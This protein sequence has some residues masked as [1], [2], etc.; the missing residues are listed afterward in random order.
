MS[1]TNTLGHQ[2][3][4]RSSDE[5]ARRVAEHGLGRRVRQGDQAF[6]IHGEHAVRGA[7]EQRAEAGLLACELLL[8]APALGD[9]AADHR[10]PCDAAVG[11]FDGRDRDRYVGQSSVLRPPHGLMVLDR[12]P[13]SDL[14]LDRGDLVVAVQRDDDRDRLSDGLCRRV[15]IE[16]LGTAVPG[17]DR[18]IERLRVDGILGGFDDRGQLRELLLGPLDRFIIGFRVEHERLHLPGV[19]LGRMIA[20]PRPRGD[21]TN[22]PA[23]GPISPDSVGR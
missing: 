19:A 3:V 1:G 9:I 4:H 7:H 17:G 6:S 18:P 12:L 21:R 13:S 2:I 20:T 11:V 5:L 22:G 15:P 8:G 16:D 10:R 23:T 14:L